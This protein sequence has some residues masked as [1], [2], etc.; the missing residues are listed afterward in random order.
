M[1]NPIPKL[2]KIISSLTLPSNG[3][4]LLIGLSGGVD[5]M[6]LTYLLKEVAQEFCFNLYAYHLH[7]GMRE[8]ADRDVI[9]LQKVTREWSIPLIVEKKS[10]KDFVNKKKISPEEAGRILR[11]KGLRDCLDSLGEG[12]I[13]TAHNADDQVETVFYRLLTGVGIRGLKAMEILKEDLFRPL[14]PFYRNEI[15][16]YA[17][18]KGIPFVVD[19]CNF[20]MQYIRN[21]VRLQIFPE[22]LKINPGFKEHLFSI[23]ED[24]KEVDY[25]MENIVK[26]ILEKIAKKVGSFWRVD[27][28]LFSGIPSVLKKRLIL[29]ILEDLDIKASRDMIH[30]VLS[31]T[32]R[33]KDVE[34]DLKTGYIAK[35]EGQFLILPISPL[36][37]EVK[38]LPDKC[39]FNYTLAIPG[40]TRIDESGVTLKVEYAKKPVEERDNEIFLPLNSYRYPLI[41]RSRLPGDKISLRRI[42]GHTRKI[43]DIMIDKKIERD[44]REAIPVLADNERVFWIIGVDKAQVGVGEEGILITVKEKGILKL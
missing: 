10:V 27:L 22:L 20:D 31:I 9:F 40:I 33:S 24:A 29:T 44:K 25:F 36:L 43:Q 37:V 18:V 2:K 26:G 6:V 11:Y 16:E 7:H 34:V 23:A 14:L 13:V 38:D 19:S 17:S 15:L 8:D 4:L 1:L 30:R 41:V 35:K 42:Q 12:Y 39:S 32:T 21:K 3:C 28:S 5:S